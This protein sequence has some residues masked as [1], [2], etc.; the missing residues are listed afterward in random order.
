MSA[1]YLVQ[2]DDDFMARDDLVWPAGLHPVEQR[3]QSEP[4]THWWLIED[5][6]AP[7]EMNGKRV[8]LTLSRNDDGTP[9]PYTALEIIS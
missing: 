9:G 6:T 2:C 8:N 3:E 1:R 5:A 7:A 4:G